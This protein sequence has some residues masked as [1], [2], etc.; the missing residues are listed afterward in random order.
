MSGFFDLIHLSLGVA[1]VAGVMFVNYKLK[2]HRFFDDDMDDL[3]ELRIGQ[4][5]L[6]VP[7]MTIQI[8]IAGFHVVW[9]ICHFKM[10]IHTTI[11]QFK[12]NLPSA[13]AK[14][15]LGN[16][17][18]LTP[19]TLTVDIDGDYFTVHAIDDKSFEGIVTDIMPRKVLNLFKKD[20]RQVVEDVQV[21]T[22]TKKRDI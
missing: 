18:T 8:I 14:M 12:A 17:I 15:I 7:W 13:H 21:I 16:S 11:I 1:S 19:G 9:I 6:F 10:P 5:I 3:S 20:G 22:Q 2:T 4:A